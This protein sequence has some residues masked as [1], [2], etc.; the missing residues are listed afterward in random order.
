M[1]VLDVSCVQQLDVGCLISDKESK[2][3]ARSGRQRRKTTT[4]GRNGWCRGCRV[5]GVRGMGE[6]AGVRKL[7]VR[8]KKS[9]EWAAGGRTEGG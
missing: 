7:A 8:G 2:K 4:R 1:M 6:A 5:C 9:L 3:Q